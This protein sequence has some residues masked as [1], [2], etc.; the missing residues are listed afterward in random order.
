MNKVQ[1]AQNGLKTSILDEIQ[2][3][4]SEEEAIL[5]AITKCMAHA[6]AVEGS[7]KVVPAGVLD[8]S[9]VEAMDMAG[10][11]LLLEKIGARA[12]GDA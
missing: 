10:R 8:W 2:Q 7:Q 5:I 6:V 1:C 4:A 11:T 9:N 12:G 3:R